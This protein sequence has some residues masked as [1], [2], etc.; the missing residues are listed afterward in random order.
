MKDEFDIDLPL[1]RALVSEQFPEFAGLPIQPVRSTG[2][3]NA[4]FRLGPNAC[5][6]LPLRRSSFAAIEK[7]AIVPTESRKLTDQDAVPPRSGSRVEKFSGPLAYTQMDRWRHAFNT[8]IW[9][10]PNDRWGAG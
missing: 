10:D 7:E 8:G 4:M 6:R 2:T 3:D 5:A 1:V 9:V